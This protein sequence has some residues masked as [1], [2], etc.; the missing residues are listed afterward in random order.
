MVPA[1]GASNRVIP[2]ETEATTYGGAD[3]LPTVEL[4]T[5]NPKYADSSNQLNEPKPVHSY[6]A[7]ILANQGLIRDNI[8]G[9]VGS[10]SMRESPSAVFGISTPGGP[11]FDGGYTRA[12]IQTMINDSKVDNSKLKIVGRTGGHTLV[13][14]DGELLSGRNQMLR[15]RSA[16]GHQITMSDDGQ[17]LFITHSN[18]QSWVELGPEGTVD[19]FSTNSF[20][21]R[22]QGDINLHADNNININAKKALNINAESISIETTMN[23][24]TKVGADYLVDTMGKHSHKVG[25]TTSIASKGAAS[26][27][28]TA[29]TFVN[30]S[31]VNLNSG[32]GPAATDVPAQ[33]QTQHV[34]TT[35]SKTKGWMY[36]APM[37]TNS[38]TS[39]LPTHQPFVSSGKGVDVPVEPISQAGSQ[40]PSPAVSTATVATSTPPAVTTTAAVASTTPS[41]SQPPDSPL[42]SATVQTLTSQNAVE[43]A[44]MTAEQRATEGVL[45]GAAGVTAKQAEAAGVLKPG[46]ATIVQQNLAMGMS[47]AMAAP[48]SFFTGKDGVKNV[49]DMTNN[50]TLQAGIIGVG[51][52]SAVTGLKAQGVIT[53]MESA[54]QISGVVNA[55]FKTDPKTVATALSAGALGIK[56]TIIGAAMSAGTFAGQLADGIKAGLGGLSKSLSDL[57]TSV[58][59]L[60]SNNPLTALAGSAKAAFSAVEQSFKNLAGGKPNVLGGGDVPVAK[61]ESPAQQSVNSYEAAKIQE[62]EAETQL[63]AA[64]KAYRN[65]PTSDNQTKVQ[66][67]EAKLSSTRQS[68]A[69][70]SNSFLQAAQMGTTANATTAA[71]PATTLNSGVNALPGGIGA[72]QSV[73]SNIGAQL[74]SFS[75]N[76]GAGLTNGVQNALS[77]QISGVLPVSL[78]AATSLIGSLK[79]KIPG[80]GVDIASA[81]AAVS[82][83]AGGLAPAVVATGTLNTEQLTAK[84]GALLGDARVPLPNLKPMPDTTTATSTQVDTG[85]AAKAAALKDLQLEIKVLAVFQQKYGADAAS[86]ETAAYLIKKQQDKVAAAQKAYDAIVST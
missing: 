30:G 58:S 23:V 56:G 29:E 82:A 24:T 84:T 35:F 47:P 14:D 31:K 68:V 86:S 63:F 28:S 64:Q 66:A 38:I 65:D 19:I 6:Q 73:S 11:V 32:S 34:E 42:N 10:T 20:N 7:A 72:L 83:G 78:A 18:G 45:P 2:N 46:T 54:T 55:A 13:M 69:Q 16:G 41:F 77:K 26:I 48:P 76:I 17:V 51:L 21:V 61:Q 43:V 57:K 52:N 50:L 53:G 62:N 74:K 8:R 39:R 85:L 70:A 9:V 59:S 5:D 1:I 22:T 4:N 49:N 44:M 27:A 60:I 75:D 81:S 36:P 80:I 37:P 3:R 12:N 40:D 33:K 71:M 79:N 15:L 67:A 25:G